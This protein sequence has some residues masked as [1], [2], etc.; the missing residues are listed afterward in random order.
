MLLIEPDVKLLK[1]ENTLVGA[2]KMAEYAG[3]ICYQSMD[4]TGSK[5]PE[6][7]VNMLLESGH[8]EPVEHATLYLKWD[9]KDEDYSHKRYNFYKHNK[10]SVLKIYE[11]DRNAYVTT[12]YRVLVE[13]N[14]L[15]DV[16]FI[17]EPVKGKHEPRLTVQFVTQ[18][19]ISKEAN[20]H[21]SNSKSELSTRYCNFSKDKFGHEINVNKP[22][23]ID[24]KDIEKVKEKETTVQVL[25]QFL[26]ELQTKENGGTDGLTPIDYWYAANVFSEF[27]Y[28][29]EI[30]G[31]WVAQ[32]ARTILPL[33]VNTMCVHTAFL[34]DWKHFLALRYFGTTG[35]PH[36][37][38]KIL[39]EKLY[40]I[41][42]QQGYISETEVL[43]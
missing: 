36:P 23:F 4:K 34:S 8:G 20:R 29:K 28:M 22:T 42:V 19:V 27:C 12:N 14:R 35:A 37:D 9:A 15:D 1:Q 31:G 17:C 18:N 7:F 3:R 30:E 25:L 26:N 6:E 38:M 43:K 41:L 32:Q 39:A 5:S 33:D 21:D 13:N 11:D 10:Y 16:A 24:E 2:F 40:K